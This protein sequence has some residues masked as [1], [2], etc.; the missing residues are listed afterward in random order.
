MKAVP[1]NPIVVAW[2]SKVFEPLVYR[3]LIIEAG[4]TDPRLTH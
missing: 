4:F 1:Q 2:T 3:L